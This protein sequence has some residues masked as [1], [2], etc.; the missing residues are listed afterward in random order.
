MSF[1]IVA[2]RSGLAAA[3]VLLAAGGFLLGAAGCNRCGAPD[4]ITYSCKPADPGTEG[5]VGP[6]AGYPRG[7]EIYPLG[8]QVQLPECLEAYPDSVKRCTCQL[9]FSP[10]PEWS[11]PI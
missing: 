6:P 3:L 5:C 10:K 4:E 11:C 2:R 1:G 8:C 9:V 7:R